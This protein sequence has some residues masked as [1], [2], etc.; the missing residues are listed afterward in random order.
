[1]SAD[2]SAAPAKRRPRIILLDTET[3]G[4]RDKAEIIEVAMVPIES[5][6]APL[7]P[8]VSAKAEFQ[9]YKPSIPIELGA[10]ATH[11]II[12]ADLVDCPP[13]SSFVFPDDV[14]YI[15][16]HNVDFDW[17]AVGKPEARRIDTLA[18]ARYCWPDLDSHKLGALIYYLFSPALAREKLRAQHSA[19]VDLDNTLDVLSHVCAL[20]EP[21]S[22][23]E[24]WQMSEE[25]RVPKVFYFGK[26][27]DKK[28]SDP[29][30]PIDY[31]Q[32]MIGKGDFDQYTLIAAKR[33]LASRHAA[34]QSHHSGG[35]YT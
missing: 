4:L 28:F 3:T 31:F 30:V 25:G 15:V 24:L 9:R 16:G 7:V 1:M 18:L 29:T 21:Q 26:H 34:R 19:S 10:M 20:K 13:S 11:H 35:S 12:D 6:Q 33:E 5:E 23:R 32:W 8:R 2:E 27:A 22:W 17:E 14:T